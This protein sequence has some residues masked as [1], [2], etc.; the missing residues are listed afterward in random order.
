LTL[1]QAVRNTARWAGVTQAEALFM[2]TAVPARLLG[3]SDLGRIASGAVADLALFDSDLQLVAT[4]VGGRVVWE[5]E[6]LF[7]DDASD[8]IPLA[9][10]SK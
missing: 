1:D 7:A 6:P 9:T 3:R 10:P 2:A 4:L 8:R 5:R